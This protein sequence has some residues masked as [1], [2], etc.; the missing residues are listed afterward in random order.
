M[1]KKRTYE[2]MFLLDAGASE[3]ESASESIRT[4][5]ERSE[6]TILS[7]KPWDERRLAYEI[8]G[9]RRAL[10]VLVYFEV[11]PARI[12]EIEHDFGLNEKV[13]RE[14]ILARKEL[15]R[16][17][18]E[19]HTP[20][21]SKAAEAKSRAEAQAAAEAQAVAEA[22][23]TQAAEAAGKPDQPAE[24]AAPA[25]APA[26]GEP[27]EAPEAIQP[28]EAPEAPEAIQ[29]AEAP[30]APEAIQP[31][32]APEPAE[33][34]PQAPQDTPPETQADEQKEST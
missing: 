15:S 13:L 32:E 29:P 19:A 22:E 12:A 26:P 34:A 18:I 2:G 10:Y 16:D 1:S 11:D 20:A 27:A 28:A 24:A 33:D 14:L 21:T 31:A 17:Q 23:K 5:L 8:K 6:S 7:M 9:R 4:V 25:E 30:E 3:F